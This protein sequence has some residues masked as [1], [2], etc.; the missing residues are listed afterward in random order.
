MV[1]K[2]ERFFIGRERELGIL[3]ELLSARSASLVVIKGRRRIGKSRLIE[4]FSRQLRTLYFLGLAPED[5]INA[6]DQ[7]RHFANQLEKQIGVGGLQADDWDHLFGHLAK[8][9]ETGSVLIV[10][11]EINWM[12][13]KDPTFLPKLKTAWDAVFSKNPQCIMILSGS[14]AGWIEDNILNSTGFFGRVTL[15]MTLEELPLKQCSL[16][17]GPYDKQISAYEKF[18]VLS[19]TGGVPLYLELIHPELSAE[20]NIER[21]AFRR[22]GLLFNE[23]D[24]IFSDLFSRRQ[25]IYRSIVEQVAL[26]PA[27]EMVILQ[28]LKHTPSGT[29]SE[30][31]DDLVSTGYLSRDYTW[32]LKT[33]KQAKHSRY[34]LK[35]NYLRFYL[36]YIEPKREL[37]NKSGSISVPV[38]HTIMGLQFENLVLNNRAALFNIIGINPGEI[39]YHNPY[40]QSKT[41]AREGCQIDLLIQTRF[42][43]LYLC[44]I[45]FSKNEIGMSVI[46]EVQEKMN[47]MVLP[48]GFSIRPVL[49]HVN[50]VAE[51]VEESA[52]FAHIIDFSELIK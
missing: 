10:L 28:A 41:K 49:I 44:V 26:G 2:K 33:K 31:L 14:M 1:K 22:E 25:A 6:A 4:E 19:V 8:Y 43:T 34:R 11:D 47:R 46:Q 48:R 12:G 15:D 32:N 18:K 24:R 39:E 7:R 42:N 3:K 36:R 38:W 9:A 50:G 5:K 51:I 35:D 16:F 29:F 37:I 20:D 27:S 40:F 52:F 17:W 23:F 45:K 21:L 13:S 30:Y